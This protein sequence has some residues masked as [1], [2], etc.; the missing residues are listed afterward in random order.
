MDCPSFLGDHRTRR[1]DV[2]SPLAITWERVS[3][4][5]SCESHHDEHPPTSFMRYLTRGRKRNKSMGKTRS[6]TKR[7]E[8]LRQMYLWVEEK[9]ARILPAGKISREAMRDHSLLFVIEYQ[10][11]IELCNLDLEINT[12]QMNGVTR[13]IMA[14]VPGF[15]IVG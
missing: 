2:P 12:D 15:G 6:R 10:P 7:A 11:P 1:Q 4:G 8:T 13:S 3:R 5:I 9:R 14:I